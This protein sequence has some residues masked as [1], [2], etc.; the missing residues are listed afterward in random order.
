[1]GKLLLIVVAIV[2]FVYAF[3]DLLATR[4]DRVRHLPKAAW[5]IVLLIPYLGAGLWIAFG[6]R[7]VAPPPPGRGRRPRGPRG[8]DDDPDYL[9]GL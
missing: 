4:S 7:R 6:T 5:F 2:L 3:F 1:M 8:P 9:R